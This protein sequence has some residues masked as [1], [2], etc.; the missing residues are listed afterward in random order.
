MSG[1]GAISR[2]GANTV[3]LAMSGD[4]SK[5]RLDLRIDDAV[6]NA[7]SGALAYGLQAS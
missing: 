3:Q 2:A 4:S 1:D 7:A 6:F 5:A